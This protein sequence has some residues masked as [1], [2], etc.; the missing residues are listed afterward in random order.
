[1]LAIYLT[2]SSGDII[3]VTVTA[4][5]ILALMGA[6]VAIPF[7]AEHYIDDRRDKTE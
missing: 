4:V 3:E 6:F 5:L 1:M 2:W 7:L